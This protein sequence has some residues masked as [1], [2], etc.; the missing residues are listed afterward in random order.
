[1][2]AFIVSEETM[3]KVVS[4][5]LAS[6]EACED[7]DRLGRK[8]FALNESAVNYRYAA[9][10]QSEP[11]AGDYSAWSWRVTSPLRNS[12]GVPQDRA[13]AC[14][15]LK[16]MHCLRYQMSEG[17]QFEQTALYQRLHKRIH[18]FEYAIVSSLPEYDAAAWD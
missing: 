1:M 2:S 4:A 17:E 10:P 12:E 5:M 18:E 13:I 14:E 8:L 15:W 11:Q 16:V 7:A 3:Q 9:R 6:H